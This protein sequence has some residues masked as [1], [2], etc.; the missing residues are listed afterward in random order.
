MP[1]IQYDV[2]LKSYN[3]FQIEANAKMFVNIQNEKDFI[4]SLEFCKKEKIEP[5]LLNGGSNILF[6]HNVEKCV[7]HIETKGIEIISENEKE[8]IIEAQA[9]ENWQN[10]VSFCVNNN[11]GGLE[12]LS[13]IPGNVGTS[14]MQ[15][16]GA[17]G[18]E[19]K[20]C[21]H[22][23]K[24][25]NINTLNFEYFDKSACHFGY[26]DSYFKNEGKGKYIIC[27]VQFRL[28]K[29]PHSIHFSY[30]AIR[31]V[32]SKKEI[33]Y[34]TIKD[35]SEAVI[36]IRKSK[37][38]DPKVIGNAGS[39]FKNPIVSNSKLNSL[40][41][42][43]PLMPFYTLKEDCSKIPAGWLIEQA[44]WKGKRFGNYGVYDKQALILVNYGGATGEE[45]YQLSQDIIED[46]KK[47]FGLTLEREVNI[48]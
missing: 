45:I 8:V 18:V 46:I 41:K 35:V 4:P 31:E 30:G 42:E 20:D 12:N 44:G 9:G 21:F 1:D 16:I 24:A 7:F 19:I 39:F 3:T 6:V 22:S 28:S 40:L 15:N 48:Y 34:P 17:Y 14:P 2:S 33:V 10:F 36:E 32:L 47:R 5:F 23:L 29:P 26:R 11:W 43:F 37:L 13:L 27:S 25:L 38:P